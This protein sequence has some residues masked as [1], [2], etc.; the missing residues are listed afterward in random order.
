MIY[1]IKE[2]RVYRSY[3]GGKHIDAFMGKSE[4]RDGRFPEDWTASVVR[5]FNPGREDVVEGYGETQDGMLVKDIPNLKIRCLVKLLDAAE[6]LVIQVHPTNEFARKYF[7]SEYGKTECWYFLDSSD[8]ACVYIGFSENVTKEQWRKAFDEQ[9]IEKMLSMLHRIP[10]KKGDCILV[11]GG[12]PHAIGAG[13]FMVEIQEPSDLMGI[14]ERKT[15]SGV[16][17]DERKLHCG[18]GI[19]KMFDMFT[20]RGTTQSQAINEYKIKPE[21]IANGVKEIIGNKSTDKFTV[22]EISAGAE[23]TPERQAG[24]FIVLSGEGRING[25]SVKK[26]DRLLFTSRENFSFVG[27]KDFSVLVCC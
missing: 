24:V 9:D 3:K 8:D 10:V 2:N 7:N 23:Y 11:K 21:Q 13:C 5:A 15:P 25:V 1:K 22:T 14:T 12:V 18:L 17:L 16:T 6:R 4:A 26:S 27:D 20:Y 19:D